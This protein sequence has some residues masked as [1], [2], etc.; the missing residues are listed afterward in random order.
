L[1]HG[2]GDFLLF[3][4]SGVVRTKVVKESKV[5]TLCAMKALEGTRGKAP[6]FLKLGTARAICPRGKKR[7]RGPGWGHRV[8]EKS[9]ASR[10]SNP[11]SPSPYL[12]TI[13]TELTGSHKSSTVA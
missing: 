13:L 8:E 3:M 1:G 11:R 10:G 2:E 9:S 7:Y 6:L 5:D 12:V 4:I